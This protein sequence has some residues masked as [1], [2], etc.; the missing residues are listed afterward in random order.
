MARSQHRG[1]GLHAQGLLAPYSAHL[2]TPELSCPP[3]LT[4]RLARTHLRRIP[5][6]CQDRLWPSLSFFRV[7]SSSRTKGAQGVKEDRTVR[8]YEAGVLNTT[9]AL[10]PPA[11]SST[12]PNSARRVGVSGLVVPEAPGVGV[13][14]PCPEALSGPAV[15]DS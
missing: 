1:E 13:S 7:S 11:P 5:A 14:R 9:W 6:L 4:T 15:S 8:P 12:A 3:H 10:T 2:P